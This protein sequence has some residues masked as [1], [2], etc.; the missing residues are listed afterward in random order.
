MTV[1]E[2]YA[3]SRKRICA[4]LIFSF[5]SSLMLLSFSA[6]TFQPDKET[7]QSRD[8]ILQYNKEGLDLLNKG[9]GEEAPNRRRFSG[10]SDGGI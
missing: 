8:T 9:S 2:S 4:I 1:K 5:I 7:R 6:C 3:M 10:L